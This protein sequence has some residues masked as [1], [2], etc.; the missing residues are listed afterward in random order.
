M[1]HLHALAPLLLV[2][3][4]L[5]GDGPFSGLHAQQPAMPTGGGSQ[6]VDRV[7]AVVA[8]TAIL[9][10]E[11]REEVFRRQ[12]QGAQVP[13][14]PAARDSFYRS[15]MESLIDERMLL[16]AAKERGV[17]VPDRQV[18]QL[19]RDRFSGMRSRF[20][21][22]E[23]F[24]QAVER[25][26]QN[27]FQFRQM[28]RSEAR[29]E[30]IVET[31][32]RRLSQSGD[33]PPADVSEEEVRRY[34]QQQA[35]GRQRPGTISFD[36]VMVVPSPDSATADSARRVAEE[37]LA[38]VRG[39]TDFAVAARRYSDD[40]GSREQGGDL[41]WVGRSDLVPAFARAAFAAP[42]GQAV[43]PVRSRFGWHVI[44]IENVR[45]GERKIRHILVRPRVTDRDVEEARELAS[46]LA[47]S[48]SEG[49]GPDRLARQ[50]GLPDEQ[51]RFQGVRLDELQGRL[52]DAYVQALTEPV[53]SAGEVRGPF[54][55]E[56]SFG[57]PAFVVARVE[58]YTPT[59][60]Y[61]LEDVRERIRENL[62]QQKQFQKFVQRLRDEMYVRVLL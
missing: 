44:K 5:A 46:A 35:A 25:T 30:L 28:I 26:G 21:S 31:L 58:D 43:G 60:E 2:P 42:L 6:T 54:R 36:R 9:L 39:G 11:V 1:R 48:L 52:D 12:Q 50:H 24:R 20:P 7:V 62:L 57:L 3:A 33:L 4:L 59:G 40:E 16:Q 8:D 14:S 34:F 51:V 22:Q 10:S 56:G 53:P 61:R 49:A 38:S 47:D 17:T 15:A 45:G 27:M 41:G 19:F 37:A 55:V 18:E 29:K 23:A 13:E 32:R